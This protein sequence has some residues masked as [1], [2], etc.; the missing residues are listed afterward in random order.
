[1]KYRFLSQKFIITEESLA[2]KNSTIILMLMK[3]IV[4]NRSGMSQRRKGARDDIKFNF[5]HDNR[6]IE[7]LKKYVGNNAMPRKKSDSIK[8]FGSNFG[9]LTLQSLRLLRC[10]HTSNE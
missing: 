7:L 3:K 1:M 5:H 8:A 6:I 10:E 9:L 2:S 4:S